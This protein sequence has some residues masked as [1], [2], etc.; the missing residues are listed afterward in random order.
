MLSL[1]RRWGAS[2]RGRRSFRC[3]RLAVRLAFGEMADALLLSS[4]RVEPAVLEDRGFQFSWPTLEPALKR[5]L[6]SGLT[7]MTGGFHQMMIRILILLLAFAAAC[8]SSS[9][10]ADLILHNGVDLD[11]R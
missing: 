5:L 8:S 10:Q 7:R 1:Q 9:Q 6:A 11:R 4:Q 2:F 3:P